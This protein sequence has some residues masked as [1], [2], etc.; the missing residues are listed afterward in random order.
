MTAGCRHQWRAARVPQLQTIWLL[1]HAQDEK[2]ED[3]NLELVCEFV[4]P[5]VADRRG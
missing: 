4:A 5:L 3:V 1:R 2:P